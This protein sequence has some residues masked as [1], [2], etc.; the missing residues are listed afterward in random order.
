MPKSLTRRM[1]SNFFCRTTS[2]IRMTCC[3]PLRVDAM[4]LMKKEP[5]IKADFIRRGKVGLRHSVQG[6]LRHQFMDNLMRNAYAL[7]VRAL[8]ITVGD[9]MKRFLLVRY[10]YS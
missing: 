2:G 4:Q 5:R 9:S 7:C 6:D 3:Y 1:A 8:T 10:L